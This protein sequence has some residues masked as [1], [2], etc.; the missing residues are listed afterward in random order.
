MPTSA[1]GFKRN[2]TD[3]ALNNTAAGRMAK[4][5][6]CAASDSSESFSLTRTFVR[7]YSAIVGRNLPFTAIQFPLYEHFRIAL[8]ER[9]NVWSFSDIHSGNVTIYGTSDGTRPQRRS[10]G[11]T[12]EENAKMVRNVV[13]KPSLV[14]RHLQLWQVLSSQRS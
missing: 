1:R 8:S 4:A 2:V 12:D 11:S 7:G 6:T 9:W 3:K 13:L 10:G 14:A 5:T